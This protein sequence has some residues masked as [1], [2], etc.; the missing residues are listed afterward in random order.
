MQSLKRVPSKLTA[1]ARYFTAEVPNS[2]KTQPDRKWKLEWS[3]RTKPP[4]QLPADFSRDYVETAD[5]NLELL[6][7]TTKE[8]RDTNKPPLFFQHGGFGSAE[9]YIPWMKYFAM[10][11]YPCYALSI[12]GH[13]YSWA[14]EYYRAVF[15]TT[16]SMLAQDVAA[17]VNHVIELHRSDSLKRQGGGLPVLLG[18]SNGGGLSQM[19]LDRGLAKASALAIL[20]GTPNFG[21]WG[22]YKN[23]AAFD[24]WFVPRMYFQDFFHPRSPLSKTSLVHRAF[25]C[26]EFPRDEVEKFEES[27]A[28]YLSYWWPMEIMRRFVNT[29]NVLSGLTGWG[30]GRVF[31]LAAEKDR[32]MSINLMGRMAH[33]YRIQRAS[34]SKFGVLSKSGI[35]LE[36]PWSSKDNKINF[37]A[38]VGIENGVGYRVVEGSGHHLQNDLQRGIAASYIEDWLI[39]LEK[40]Q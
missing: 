8:A 23:W 32:L 19:L 12:R 2:N 38:V 1:H 10:R 31:V 28:A 11:G 18:H 4:P 26:D 7:T 34:M 5:G 9:V 25:F 22:V 37:G 29:K 24:P 30:G 3:P 39:T 14:P 16:A 36:L 6:K 17:G 15:R 21:G 13:G 40:S 35:D 27:M 33:E 20:A